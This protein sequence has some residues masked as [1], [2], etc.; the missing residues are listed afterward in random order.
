MEDKDI[1]IRPAAEGDYEFV[2]QTNR[3]NVKFLSPMDRGRLLFLAPM[4]EQFLVAAVDGRPAA[5]LMALR[6]G[7]TAYDSENYR[8]FGARYERFLY[9]DRI[10]II[11]PFRHMGIG[12]RLYEAVFAHARAIG[13]PTVTCE[14]DIIPYNG[15]SLAFHKEMGF[16]EVGTQ[17]VRLNDVTVSLLVRDSQ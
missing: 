16:R 1:V 12:R 5:F 7:A 3:D 9:I 2:L 4:C 17:H 6:E 11:E 8:W 14:V 13:A 10:A 15:P